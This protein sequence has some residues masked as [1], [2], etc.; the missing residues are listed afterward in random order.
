MLASNRHQRQSVIRK[1]ATGLTISAITVLLCLTALEFTLRIW[2]PLGG[3][4]FAPD[5]KVIY[6]PIPNARKRKSPFPG[7]KGDSVLVTLNAEGRRGRAFDPSAPRHVIVY[8][9]SFVVAESTPVQETFPVQLER[10]LQMQRPQPVQVVNAGVVGY[11]P[12]QASLVMEDE[13]ARLKPDLVIF[14]IFTGNDFGDLMRNKLFLLNDD[15]GLMRVQPQL[16]VVSDGFNYVRKQSRLQLVRYAKR[17]YKTFKQ[18]CGTPGLQL[19]ALTVFDGPDRSLPGLPRTREEMQTFLRKTVED[20]QAEYRDF[21]SN[22]NLRVTAP[23]EDMLD[24]DVLVEPESESALYKVHLIVRV[25]ERTY[26]VAQA[27]KVPILFLVIPHPLDIGNNF[28]GF[29]ASDESVIDPAEFP[30]YRRSGVSDVLAQHLSAR[31]IP[32][33]DLFPVFREH[34]TED[35]Y[36]PFGDDHWTGAGQRLAAQTVAEYL[37][38]H[39]LLAER[40]DVP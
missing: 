4:F 32:F 12:D 25:L 3:P 23:L 7:A 35:L 27:R 13:I 1:L 2:F 17:S 21:V 34:R 26:E 24:A 38:S 15:G 11:G 5:T 31:H 28:P 18:M 9:D 40:P 37:A 8:G 14:A 19:S 6:K 30:A 20:R 36:L 29:R 33:V 39:A 16:D 22:R 10:L